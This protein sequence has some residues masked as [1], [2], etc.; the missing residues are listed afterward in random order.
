[1]DV[2][3]TIARAEAALPGERVPEDE[4]D[5][6]WQAIIALADFI[7]SDPEPVW[8]FVE[9]WGKHADDDL[10]AAVATCLLEH[11]LEHHFALIYPRM[12]RLARSSHL[13]AETV[14]MCW[15]FGQSKVPENA[16]RLESLVEGTRG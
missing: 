13:F 10:R 14:G 9:R 4:R 16:A 3:E 6:R 12:E 1:M 7:E 8:S 11:L 5:P 2:N 15:Q